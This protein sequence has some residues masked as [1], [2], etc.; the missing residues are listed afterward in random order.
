[1]HNLFKDGTDNGKPVNDKYILLSLPI[2]K[3]TELNTVLGWYA[4]LEADNAK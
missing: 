2:M 3:P 4:N 1:M